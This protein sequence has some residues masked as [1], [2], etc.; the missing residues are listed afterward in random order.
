MHQTIGTDAI[1]ERYID[2]RELYVG[3]LG[4]Q[5]LQMLPV[6]ELHLTKMPEEAWHIA[7]DRVKWNRDYQKKRGVKTAEAK[8]LPDGMAEQ[9][10]RLCKRVYRT[11]DLSGYAR[12]DMRLD[13]NGRIYVLEANPNPQLAY[14]EDFS[15]SAEKAGISY[16]DLLQR[17]I[18]LGM[19][20][21]PERGA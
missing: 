5:R 3:V 10:H 17:I 20:W 2:G 18:N 1:A 21:R 15:E 14:G 9:I 19:R 12:I 11:L 16:R 6:W 4:N 13:E 7:T 8:G